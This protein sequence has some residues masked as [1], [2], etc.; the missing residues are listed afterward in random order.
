MRDPL[1]ELHAIAEVEYIR[2]ITQQL[3]RECL[4]QGDD[5]PLSDMIEDLIA[6]GS[7]SLLLLSGILEELR[8]SRAA[9]FQEMLGLR[10]T[11][12]GTMQDFGVEVPMLEVMDGNWLDQ[13]ADLIPIQTS[14]LSEEDRS[15]LMDIAAE[16][17]NQM[18][19]MAGRMAI[20]WSLE[21]FLQDW[22]GGLTYEVAHG[23]PTL[24]G[25]QTIH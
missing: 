9:L 21:S 3:I 7:S 20:L 5:A 11:L 14:G 18:Q 10:Q 24:E 6:K 4:D 1:E 25:E 13:Q 17:G 15:F 19:T 23:E 12:I 16:L 8:E 22:I 2:D